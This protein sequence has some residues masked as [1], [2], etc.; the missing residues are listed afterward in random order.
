MP[1]RPAHDQFQDDR[2]LT[3][4]FPHGAASFCLRKL[5]PAR[6]R[7][8]GGSLLSDRS[9]TSPSLIVGIRNKANFPFHR[10]W[11]FFGFWMMVSR[12]PLLVI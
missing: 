6:C 7:Q 3:V 11:L 2:Q 5:L 4:L 8:G 12:T 1:V 10:T 9:P